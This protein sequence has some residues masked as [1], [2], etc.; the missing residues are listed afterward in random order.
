M[1]A[2]GSMASP[3]APPG[4]GRGGYKQ[5][6]HFGKVSPGPLSNTNDK[7]FFVMGDFALL[8]SDSGKL[9]EP[10]QGRSKIQGIL[11]C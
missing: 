1:G 6:G 5:G 7:L 4:R 3:L 10:N 8:S 2:S 11:F 9:K